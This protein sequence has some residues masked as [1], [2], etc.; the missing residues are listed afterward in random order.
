MGMDS[1]QKSYFNNEGHLSDESIA[2]F[3]EHLINNE[4][5]NVDTKL[6]EHVEDCSKC[7]KNIL[8]LCDILDEVKGFNSEEERFNSYPGSYKT[9]QHTGGWTN[10]RIIQLAAAVIITVGIIGIIVKHNLNYFSMQDRNGKLDISMNKLPVS[11]EFIDTMPD[12]IIKKPIPPEE[13][14]K[15]I[16]KQK[17]NYELLAANFKQN[18]AYEELL[19]SGLRSTIALE[20]VSPPND[21]HFKMNENIEIEWRNTIGSPVIFILFNNLGVEVFRS[22]K[23]EVPP[24]KVNYHPSSGL[25]YWKLETEDDLLHIGKF[26]VK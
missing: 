11:K 4:T 3:A 22:I 8:S 24:I 23:T 25:Y 26:T 17:P 2:Y 14:Q 21:Y 1:G 7:K 20:S 10:F 5:T 9:K 19:K 13:N 12:K 15:L 6:L 16:K 18:P